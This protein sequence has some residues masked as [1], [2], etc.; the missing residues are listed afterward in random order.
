MVILFLTTLAA[1][2]LLVLA[3]C[4]MDQVAWSFVRLIAILALCL[5][6]PVLA[7]FALGSR[8][9]AGPWAVWGA[10][11]TGLAALAAFVVLGQAPVAPAYGRAVRV[12]AGVGGLLALMAGWAWGLDDGI[13]AYGQR[14]VL[15]AVLAGHALTAI[16]L[17]AVSLATALGHA[18][19]THTAMTIHPLRRLA[20]VF[21]GAM[22]ARIAWTLLVGGA[23][24]G[25]GAAHGTVPS[26]LLARE[27]LLLLVRGGVGLLIPAVFAYMVV[28]TVRLRAT[29]SATGILYFALV[30][31][32]IGELAGL[33]LVRETHL[34]L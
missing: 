9:E 13:W 2:F 3:M 27:W 30:L 23:V 31:I 19:L 25:Y 33:Y 5:L 24:W 22:A 32:Y 18:Y 21:A 28:E 34:P 8:W 20:M 6:V 1:G 15:L 17:G 11:L 26:D 7:H 29:Q 14:A 12:G 16:L 10:I 4:R